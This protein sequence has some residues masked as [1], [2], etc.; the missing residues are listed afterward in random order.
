MA[1]ANSTGVRKVATVTPPVE[2]YGKF[3]DAN[4]KENEETGGATLTVRIVPSS[5]KPPEAPK[6]TSRRQPTRRGR[7]SPRSRGKRVERTVTYKAKGALARTLNA[8]IKSQRIVKDVFVKVGLVVYEGKSYRVLFDLAS[9]EPVDK[10]DKKGTFNLP[11]AIVAREN[12]E[13][14]REFETGGEGTLY[15]LMIAIS[16]P[17]KPQEELIIEVVAGLE[18]A[19]EL[20]KGVKDGDKVKVKG[21][22]HAR[23]GDTKETLLVSLHMTGLSKVTSKK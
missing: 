16:H 22:L 14:L 10:T 4:F 17:K 1:S 7:P 8:H 20:T 19:T 23:A 6:A 5:Y 12:G 3:V 21:N 2:E 15:A 9:I 11:G 18:K 13:L